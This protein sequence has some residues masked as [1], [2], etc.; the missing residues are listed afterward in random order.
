M[1][2]LYH[3]SDSS[4]ILFF[5]LMNASHIGTSGVFLEPGCLRD[6]GWQSVLPVLSSD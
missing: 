3:I 1:L 4:L 6:T 2:D 5:A